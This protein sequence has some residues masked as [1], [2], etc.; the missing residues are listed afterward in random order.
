[1]SSDMSCVLPE[2]LDWANDV[3][4]SVGAGDSDESA[5]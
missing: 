4:S 3:S 1:M 2:L 5:G